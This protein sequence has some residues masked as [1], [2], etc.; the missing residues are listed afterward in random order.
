MSEQIE[1]SGPVPAPE[2]PQSESDQSQA[3]PPARIIEQ[4]RRELHIGPLPHP[5]ILRQYDEIC[6]GSAERLMNMAERQSTHRMSM[7]STVVNGDDKRANRGLVFGLVISLAFLIVSGLL[8]YS[9]HDWAGAAL[10]SLD[11]IGLA[12]VFV[13]GTYSRRSERAEKT[14]IMTQALDR[15]DSQ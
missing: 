5:D 13:V 10:A 7:E 9:G 1:N 6:P 4:I 2:R 11:I 3:V 8:I 12:A 15:R 14:A